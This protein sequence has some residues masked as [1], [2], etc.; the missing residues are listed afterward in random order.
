M[1]SALP[2][3]GLS[4]FIGCQPA[5]P[6][7]AIGRAEF[8][9]APFRPVTGLDQDL[10]PLGCQPVLDL[11]IAGHGLPALAGQ[12]YQID[13]PL[14][15]LPLHF[16][17]EIF[18]HMNGL[19]RGPGKQT[20]G[21]GLFQRGAIRRHPDTTPGQLSGDVRHN[22]RIGTNDKTDQPMPWLYLTRGN[23]LALWT[24]G[25]ILGL[26]TAPHLV[27]LRGLTH[28]ASASSVAPSSASAASSS[29]SRSA[30]S[31]QPN[32]T[33]AVITKSCASSS[34]TSNGS[35]RPSSLT[36]SP[37]TVV[38]PPASSQSAQVAKSSSVL[39]PSSANACTI[40]GVRPSNSTRLSSAP[41]SRAFSRASR[42][43]ASSTS[44]ARACNSFAVSSSTPSM[45]SNS[46][47]ST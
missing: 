4:Q 19:F 5:Y 14:S 43:C 2:P 28:Q 11:F 32:M 46:S 17:H 37:S 44:R 8:R 20:L 24:I 7:S 42:A 27:T 15:E 1:D 38:Q 16:R 3:K 35:S 9:F 18:G 47:S 39:T 22:L 36:R 29:A 26:P 6:G 13:D 30:G 41:S 23:A 21:N 12:A 25:P 10:C 45:T 40:W 33:R 31:T 34:D